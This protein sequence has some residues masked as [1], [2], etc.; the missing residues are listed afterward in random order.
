MNDSKE[1]TIQTPPAVPAAS[2]TENATSP[3]TTPIFQTPST[4]APA[5][6]PP[7]A[8]S[9]TEER[10]SPPPAPASA[11]NSG[12]A[13]FPPPPS[14]DEVD[15]KRLPTSSAPTFTPSEARPPQPAP[16]PSPPPMTAENSPKPI[17]PATSPSD[18][19]KP[20]VAPLS[21][22]TTPDSNVRL[23]PPIANNVAPPTRPSQPSPV[24]AGEIPP[25]GANGTRTS[26]P[27]A[28]PVPPS[29]S[30]RTT[31]NFVPQVE[32]YDEETY[33]CKAGDTLEN[34]SQRY[35]A[36]DKYA[37]ALLL[38]NRNH[39]RPAAGLAS[40]PP[41]LVDGQPLYIPPP[42]ILD[43]YYA[44]A[45][46]GQR[47]SPSLVVPASATTVGVPNTGGAARAGQRYTVRQPEMVSAIARNT[48]GNLERWSEIYELNGRGF[49]PSRPIPAGTVLVMPADARL[50]PDS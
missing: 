5:A 17:S 12:H 39:P 15:S 23:N 38:F 22:V 41:Q 18:V 11:T 26:P 42:H 13:P 33:R 47:I 3:A 40:D 31:S 32:S 14:P 6:L 45:V 46:P 1:E 25:V 24:P 19:T 4:G 28:V 27:I 44:Y 21:S 2:P 7:T 29:S 30:G 16:A 35:F 20:A 36:T 49:D 8:P 43:K 48:L 34:V 9:T 50:A 10:P 37:R